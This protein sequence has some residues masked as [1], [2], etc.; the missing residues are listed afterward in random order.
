MIKGGKAEKIFSDRLRT[1]TSNSNRILDIGTSQRF[2]KELRPYESLFSG[3]EYIAAG[4][5]PEMIYD[6]YN[7]DLHADIENMPFEDESFDAVI[8]LEVLEHVANPFR[9]V[10]EIARVIKP[11][12]I[13]MLTTPFLLGYHGKSKKLSEIQSHGHSYYP[14]YWRFTHE[15]LYHLHKPY[16]NEIELDVL[17]GPLEVAT[18]VFNLGKFLRNALIRKVMDSIDRPKVGSQTTRH[19]VWARKDR[20]Y[21]R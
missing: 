8:C 6:N 7:C 19:L 5:E 4:Y 11:G 1:L 12:G 14:D 17:N 3:K 9:A 13:L 2:A 18:L 16:Y 21:D 20:P 10:K 15:G